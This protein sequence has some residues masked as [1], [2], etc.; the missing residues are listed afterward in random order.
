MLFFIIVGVF[1]NHTSARLIMVASID[2]R[3]P[4]SLGK[5]NK[6][7]VPANAL[8]VQ[9]L[10]AAGY[11]FLIFFVAPLITILGD[12]AVLTIKAYMVTAAALLIAWAFSFIFPFINLVILYVRDQSFV[13]SK[14]VLPMPILW[15]SMILGPIVCLAAIVDTLLFSWIPTLIPNS[16]WLLLVGGIISACLLALVVVS[17]FA[18]SQAAWEDLEKSM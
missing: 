12:P 10:A 14:K 18:N 7:R 17:L 16:A 2:R 5:L 4:L 9:T 11:S 13:R 3:L 15:I 1:E 6:H 8:I